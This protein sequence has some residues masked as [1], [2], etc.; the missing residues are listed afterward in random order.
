MQ[1]EEK[2]CDFF[3]FILFI[4][5]SP[6]TK[7]KIA[8]LK[9]LCVNKS[10]FNAENKKV[11][12]AVFLG[13]TLANLNPFDRQFARTNAGTHRPQRERATRIKLQPTKNG[14]WYPFTY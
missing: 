6:R 1:N 2:N 3:I 10:D 13:A 12:F 5:A 9:Y 11:F 8:P 7:K 4:L 14:G